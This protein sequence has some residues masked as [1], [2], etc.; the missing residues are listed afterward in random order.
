MNTT[1]LQRKVVIV[2][3]NG[4]HLR[5]IR[6]FVELARQFQCSLI[7][8]HNDQT[9][10]GRSPLDLMILGAAHGSELTLE[11]EGPDA[12]QALDAL[13]ELLAKP[14]PPDGC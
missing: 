2:N 10:D 12:Q 13:A 3:P 14:P 7:V 8:T 11:A 9:V 6:A 1:R 4:L 5:P